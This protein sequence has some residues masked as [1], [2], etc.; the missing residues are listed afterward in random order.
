MQNSKLGAQVWVLATYMLM[1]GLKGQSTMKLLRD[2]GI[3]EK[4]AWH[5]AHRIRETWSKREGLFGGPVAIDETY[6]CGKERNKYESD[7]LKSGRGTVGK[8]AVLG[9]R[10]AR[11]TAS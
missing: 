10:T 2:L 6:I 8:T 3:S 11:R 5:L 9:S 1:T 4:S 7:K